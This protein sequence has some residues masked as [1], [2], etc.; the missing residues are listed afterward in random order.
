M[1]YYRN[2]L[3]I[4]FKQ[5]PKKTISSNYIISISNYKISVN[6]KC[7]LYFLIAILN[8]KFNFRNFYFYIVNQFII[9]NTINIV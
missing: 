5:R 3:K 4:L 7:F 6:V 1:K 9:K 8:S 2:C